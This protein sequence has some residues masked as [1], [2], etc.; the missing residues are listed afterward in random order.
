MMDQTENKSRMKLLKLFLKKLVSIQQTQ[1]FA[2][3]KNLLNYLKS[4]YSLR[5]V[6]LTFYHF[7]ESVKNFYMNKQK[8]CIVGDGL[9][10]LMTAL[11]LSQLEGLEVHLISK[12]NKHSIDKRTT[13][14]SASNYEFFNKVVGKLDKKLFW[15]SKKIDL[16]Y[17]TKDQKIN[18]LNF[19]EDNK[20]LMYV[21]ENDKIKEILIKAIKKKKIKTLQKNINELKDLDGY[22][23]K[24]LCL[25]R[26]SKIYKSVIDKRS[27]NKDY[28]E[29]ALTA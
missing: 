29:I 15:P 13:S 18:F 8:I 22:D 23:I 6:L 3:S 1:R 7:Y 17:E 9:S 24:V 28:R 10:G 20:N 2:F 25:G 27:L 14:I 19:N 4:L 12:K 11:A 26:S 21:F 5:I 16:F